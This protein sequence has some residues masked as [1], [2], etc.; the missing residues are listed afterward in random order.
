MGAS[1]KGKSGNII[2]PIFIIR[3]LQSYTLAAEFYHCFYQQMLMYDIHS[4]PGVSYGSGLLILLGTVLVGLFIGSGIAGGVWVAMTG[5]S[6][7]SMATDILNP[8]YANVIR[9]IQLV[10]TFFIFFIPAYIT[11]RVLSKKPFRFLGFNNYFS[12]KQ[13]G[14]AIL[15]MLAALPLVGAL[16]EVNKLIPISE[17]MAAKFK[18][19]EDN[20]AEQ[21]K[22]LSKISGIGEYIVSLLIMAIA[23]AIFEETLFRGGLQN[24]LQKITKNPWIAIG[25][26][27]IIFSAIHASYYGFI[28]RVALG[29]VLGLL[30]YY[31]QSLWLPI[32]A[33]CF[34]NALVV[35]QIYYYTRQGKPIEEAMNESNPIWWGLIALAV[36]IFLFRI[37]KTNAGK[38]L[39]AKKPVEDIA[40]EDQWMS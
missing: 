15:I 4:R 13:V 20:Y 17:S 29:V 16:S 33:H 24:L 14:I 22:V 28:P 21:V 34:N 6:I 27:S 31:S 38:D 12:M 30:F 7:F 35:T 8:K 1:N 2:L 32:I 3:R 19:W 40:L 18:T 9:V 25:I 37:Y 36:I 23:P 26:T 5:R 39:A 10:S 11:A